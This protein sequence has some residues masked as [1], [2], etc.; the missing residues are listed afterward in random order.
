M[1]SIIKNLIKK[2]KR[3]FEMRKWEKENALRKT[4]E[5]EEFAATL[6]AIPHINS[7]ELLSERQFYDSTWKVGVVIDGNEVE[8]KIV[9][10]FM[11]KR[12]ELLR[13]LEKATTVEAVRALD[14][15]NT[16]LYD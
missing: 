3:S 4:L 14:E 7:L 13:L 11:E 6:A 1:I 8:V 5:R 10:D 12:T 16:I 2:I 15:R 9:R